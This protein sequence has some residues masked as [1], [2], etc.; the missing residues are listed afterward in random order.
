MVLEMMLHASSLAHAGAGKDDGAAV[1][2]PDRLALLDRFDQVEVAA[3]KGW[4][5]WAAVQGAAMAAKHL[6]CTAGERGIQENRD[7]SDL[8]V[9]FQAGNVV[10]YLLGA[11]H[12]KHG[13]DDI[14]ARLKRVAQFASKQGPAFGFGWPRPRAVARGLGWPL[15]WVREWLLGV[16]G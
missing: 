10:E 4:P 2:A 12:G 6:G 14:A 15:P 3:R 16:V 5:V 9:M 7:G 1:D 11:L 8:A 13:N